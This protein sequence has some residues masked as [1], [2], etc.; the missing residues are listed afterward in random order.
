MPVSCTL[1]RLSIFKIYCYLCSMELK[2]KV[3]HAIDTT[4]NEMLG[5][6]LNYWAET[7]DV[8]LYSSWECPCCKQICNK[9]DFVGAHVI[10]KLGL[11]YIIPTC[12]FC[13]SRY[14]NNK[15]ITKWFDVFVNDLVLIK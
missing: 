12:R 1:I 15:A 11:H 13:N 9:A 2:V 14:K 4:D 7:L 6:N 10:D 8:S 3:R 5:G